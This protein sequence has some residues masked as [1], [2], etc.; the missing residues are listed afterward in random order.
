VCH[1]ETRERRKIIIL[2]GEQEIHPFESQ[3]YQPTVTAV[4]LEKQS[5]SAGL[6]QLSPDSKAE[7]G[8]EVGGP[9]VHSHWPHPDPAGNSPGQGNSQSQTSQNPAEVNRLGS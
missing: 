8:R 7:K 3:S 6:R 9:P 5:E 1:R 2:N 4:K